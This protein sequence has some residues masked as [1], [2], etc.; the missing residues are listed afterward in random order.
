MYREFWSFILKETKDFVAEF[1]LVI[2]PFDYHR[3]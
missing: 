2:E 3:S 1:S